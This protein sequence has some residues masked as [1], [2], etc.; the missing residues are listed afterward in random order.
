MSRIVFSSL[1]LFLFSC[2]G[3][4]PIGKFDRNKLYSPNFLAE[5]KARDDDL[6][7][8]FSTGTISN[9]P[10]G[11]V[12]WDSSA[13]RWKKWDG[14]AWGELASTYALTALTT[15]GT[16]GF[17]GNITITGT[18][19]ASSTVSGTA[20]IPDGS[21]VPANGVY[22]PASNRIGFS[23]G[24]THSAAL[25][26]TGLKLGTG[27]AVCKLEVDGGIKVAG[28]ITNG[29]HGYGFRTNDTDGGMYSPA[30]NTL[31][32]KTNNA[33]RVSIVGSTFGINVDN[34]AT[35]LHVRGGGTGSTN[36]RLQN[37]DGYLQFSV[38]ADKAR[39]QADEHVFKN[40]SDSSTW[41]TLNSTGFGINKTPA[42]KLDV[43]GD[44]EISGTLTVGSLSGTATKATDLDINASNKIVYQ[45][46]DGNSSTLDGGTSGQ[47]LQSKGASLPEWASID[48]EVPIGGIIIWSGA[49]NAIPTRWSLCNGDT[50]NG[51][52]TPDLRNRFVV[53][54]GSTYSVGN[55]GGFTDAINISHTHTTNSTG[56]HGHSASTN[57][58]GNHYHNYTDDD[59]Q[60]Q[61]SKL[62]AIGVSRQSSMGGGGSTGGD[63]QYGWRTNTT[64]NHSHTVS[65]NS[66]GSHSHSVNSSGSS[67]SGRNLPPYYALC[68]IMRT[69]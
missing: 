59:H 45:A 60:G 55:T 5:V 65:V 29:S 11:A 16:A 27:T 62:A 48:G 54:A 47:F 58:T 34:P 35:H 19:D 32:F 33:R 14:S 43:S 61:A 63:T 7:V 3:I 13:N 31:T 24:S 42:K 15:T 4:N 30:D 36:F 56:S 39:Y 53:G 40:Q 21:T 41:A 12:K 23:T 2:A 26:S 37:D 25:D 17:G 9:Q 44:A 8:Q 46:S 28:G 64:G 67:G 52:A 38:D 49:S 20:F 1:L 50:V 22:L 66:G 10:T 68:Y 69:S 6:S 57:T 51:N 18:V